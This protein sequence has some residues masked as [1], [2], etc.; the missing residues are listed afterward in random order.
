MHRS[1]PEAISNPQESQIALSK[2]DCGFTAANFEYA[3]TNHGS[4]SS[5]T[6]ED[7]QHTGRYT[8][9]VEGKL[10]PNNP[11]ASNWLLHQKL[12]DNPKKNRQFLLKPEAAKLAVMEFGDE[13]W[14]TAS[15]KEVNDFVS[16][17]IDLNHETHGLKQEHVAHS[18]GGF[19][20]PVY[21]DLNE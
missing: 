3:L 17:C 7:A 1:V 2:F 15:F 4:G 10:N 18:V 5:F 11:S 13:I 19:V 6:W 8:I 9:T 14:R 16:I 20:L 12:D 21:K